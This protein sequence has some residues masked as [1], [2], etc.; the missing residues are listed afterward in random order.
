MNHRKHMKRVLWIALLFPAA[1]CFSA[2]PEIR[3]WKVDG[4][5]REALVHLPDGDTPAPLVFVFHGHGGNMRNS[6]RSFRIHEIWP[7][8]AVVYMQGL[9]TPG[10]L[11]DPEG[12]KNGWN[13]DPS[14][15][16]NRDLKFFDAVYSSLQHRIDTRRAFSTGHSNGGA[17]TYC[18]W[19][20]RHDRLTA[21]APS[22]SAAGRSAKMLKPKPVL[23]VAGENDP[24]VKYAWQKRMLQHIRQLNGC[25]DEGQRWQ[26]SGT[27]TGT[28][29]S[30]KKGTPLVTLIS[31]GTHKFPKEAP[32]L[33]VRFFQTD[34]AD[35]R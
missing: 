5:Q 21:V 24:L 2:E 20:A 1:V 28:L 31:P 9:P 32:E 25:A 12:R 8:A 19:A 22:A 34:W 30:S 6:A 13:A 27:L 14:D 29:Y 33:I 7:E 10:R 18:L 16:E 35:A 11:T 23:H 4:L 26:S 15:P 17:F 3:S